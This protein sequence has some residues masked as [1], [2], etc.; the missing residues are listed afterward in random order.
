MK[1]GV[2]EEALDAIDDLER[3]GNT[4]ARLDNI[5]KVLVHLVQGGEALSLKQH[6]EVGRLQREMAERQF[7]K[8]NPRTTR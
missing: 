3:D 7:G 8:Q 1:P 6:V 4:R 2:L 5:E